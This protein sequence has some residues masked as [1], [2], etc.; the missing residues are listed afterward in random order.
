MDAVFIDQSKV[1]AE[2]PDTIAYTVIDL[3]MTS[4]GFSLRNSSG[5]RKVLVSHARDERLLPRSLCLSL[6]QLEIQLRVRVPVDGVIDSRAIGLALVAI[7]E[8][9]TVSFLPMKKRESCILVSAI[10][11]RSSS[12]LD[13]VRCRRFADSQIKKWGDNGGV[14]DVSRVDECFRC[15]IG[16]LGETGGCLLRGDK[17]A[18]GVD[19]EVFVKVGE[20]ERERVIGRVGGHCTAFV[21]RLNKGKTKSGAVQGQ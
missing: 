11:V 6:G 15:G 12:G 2:Y 4:L 17:G 8:P 18:D 5:G 14:H 16:E 7:V 20:L 9:A 3:K 13:D 21:H 19:V 10:L 1:G